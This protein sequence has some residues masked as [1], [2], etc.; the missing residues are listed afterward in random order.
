MKKI[1]PFAL[2]IVFTVF[3][4]KPEAQ[5][6]QG[7][8][9]VK[10]VKAGKPAVVPRTVK[11]MPDLV[12]KD[13][14]FADLNN[15]NVIDGGEA[16]YINFKI[17]N[18]G[19]GVA[20]NVTVN[21]SLKNNQIRGLT[22]TPKV[23]VGNIYANET[24]DVTINL[25]GGMNLQE[26]LAEF[27]IEVMEEQGF[28]AYPLEMKIETAPF[29][30]PN[31]VVADAVFSTESGG[32]LKLNTTIT[33][34]ALIQN[35]GKGD[36]QDVNLS[37][38]FPNPDCV[39]LGEFGATDNLP[40]GKMKPGDVKEMDFVFTATRRYKESNIP[41][42]VKIKEAFGKYAHDTTVRVQ[43][44]QDLVAQNNVVIN[45]IATPT[46]TVTKASL[47]SE[48]DKNIP[49][50]A[51]KNPNKYALIIGNEEYSKFQ[52][53]LNTEMNVA[54][55]RNDAMVFR[56]YVINTLGFPKD[57]VLFLQDATT[58]EMNQKLDL[59]SKLVATT[60]ASAE[61]LFYYAGHGLPDETTHIPYLIPVDVSGTNIY[62]AIKLSDIYK[63]FSETGA[64]KITVILDA[65]F[66]GG[67][68]ESGLLAARSVKVKP[69]E[70]TLNGNML[71]FSASSGE[72]SALPY[73]KEKHGIFTFFV[74]KKLQESSGNLTYKEL[75][76]YVIKNV[77]LESL[78]VNEKQ[79]NPAVNIS[80]EVADTWQGWK[81]K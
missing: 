48:V 76:D 68:R 52:T 66:T 63:K 59:I 5:V 75:T 47:S 49:E 81:L 57:N 67:G 56:D 26:A 37:F 45:A 33:L 6:I 38:N 14:I 24:K 73:A 2:A 7:S 15:N 22:F 53:G 11:S 60:G 39:A 10:K 54:F 58:G 31:I 35:I 55:A 77:S 36:A 40:I 4:L 30:P 27:K 79:Q 42:N 64:K 80:V 43:I 3:I 23:D 19:A 8:S 17:Q 21:V 16:S 34:K 78:K 29:Q 65:C 69:A 9:G 72:Q 18:L 74:L 71:V 12:I 70:E 25:S 46:V 41:V 32:K 44:D 13:E 20:K 61:L 28:D 51:Q 62:S 50:T 1:L